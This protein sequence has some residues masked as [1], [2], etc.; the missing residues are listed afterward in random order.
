MSAKIRFRRQFAY[1][2][3]SIS[4]EFTEDAASAGAA[5]DRELKWVLGIL[6]EKTLEAIFI[7]EEKD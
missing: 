2:N 1:T 7:E 5:L 6:A 4:N 3:G